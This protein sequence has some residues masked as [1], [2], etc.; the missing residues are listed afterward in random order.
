MAGTTDAMFTMKDF[1]FCISKS[2][3][4]SRGDGVKTMKVP[5]DS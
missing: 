5:S 1:F 3:L 4:C 2:A